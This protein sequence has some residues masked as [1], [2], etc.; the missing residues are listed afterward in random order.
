M[1]GWVVIRLPRQVHPDF[2]L[3]TVVVAALFYVVTIA[4]TYAYLVL[5][6]ETELAPSPLLPSAGSNWGVVGILLG[7]GVA[8]GASLV[9]GLALATL[10]RVRASAIVPG[11]AAGFGA[12]LLMYLVFQNLFHTSL[13]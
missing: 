13:I 7:F 9:G 11:I 4:A 12:V 3:S 10:G 1:L 8:L 6:Y 5:N 2:L